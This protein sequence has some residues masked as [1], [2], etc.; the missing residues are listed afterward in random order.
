MSVIAWYDLVPLVSY[1]VLAG[2]CR[3]CGQPISWLYPFIECC[4]AVAAGAVW[5]DLYTMGAMTSAELWGRGVAYSLFLSGFVVATRTDL[6]ALV[7]PRVVIWFMAAVGHVAALY[8][9]LPVTMSASVIGAVLGYGSLWLLNYAS[10]K[11][12]GREG[13][14]EGDMELLAVVGIFWG[15]IGVWAV[16]LIASLAG[17]VCA[18]FYVLVTGQ[19]RHT[20][21][22]F[23]PFMAGA[24]V[25]YLFLQQHIMVFLF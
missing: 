17:I 8:A 25:S 2:K 20:R 5:F 12:S 13:I 9:V 11:L 21:I 24:A 23:I 14:G 3:A 15:P 10:R 16:T 22:P 6:A 19:G 7:V 1:V 4:G 18:T